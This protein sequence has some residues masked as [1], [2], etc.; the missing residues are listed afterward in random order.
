MPDPLKNKS[1]QSDPREPREQPKCGSKTHLFQKRANILKMDHVLDL[2]SA[3]GDRIELISVWEGQASWDTSLDTQQ[4]CNRSNLKIKFV[5]SWGI[6][7]ICQKIKKICFWSPCIYT[8]LIRYLLNNFQQLC[9]FCYTL[10]RGQ[11][12]RT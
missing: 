7:K 8:R 1:A 4:Q 9:F 2:F 10:N 12:C 11:G 3:L 6:P 5:T